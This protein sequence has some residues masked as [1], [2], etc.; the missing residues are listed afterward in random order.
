[1]I[2]YHLAKH[3]EHAAKLRDELKTTRSIDDTNE[4][5]SLN[6]LNAVITETLRLYPGVPAGAPR[7]TPR[8]GLTIAGKHIPGNVSVIAPCYSIGRRKQDPK[9][10]TKLERLTR[11]TQSNL[12]SSTPTTS[13][14]SA[15]TP[16][17]KWSETQ[18]PINPF[19]SVNTLDP[20]KVCQELLLNDSSRAIRM[21]G[22]E[23]GAD[24]T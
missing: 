14:P 6:H 2:F 23:L 22:Q 3:P 8:E 20:Y 9:K 4:L 11:R 19:F 12:V 16:D 5:Q 24:A 1:M 21:R 13:S 18:T 10:H 17:P 15:G 7:D